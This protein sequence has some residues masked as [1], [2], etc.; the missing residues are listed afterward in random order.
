MCKLAQKVATVFLALL[1]LCCYITPAFAQDSKESTCPAF[2]ISAQK[3]LGDRILE[4]SRNELVAVDRL[5]I[6]D[7]EFYMLV[8]L[9]D[10]EDIYFLPASSYGAEKTPCL[11]G[12]PGYPLCHYYKPAPQ[13]PH[14]PAIKDWG[15]FAVCMIKEVFD[16]DITADLA[17]NIRVQLIGFVKD[18]AINSILKVLGKSNIW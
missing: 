17:S 11:P 2:N 5:V 7:E 3:F 14:E 8:N 16:I 18:R 12:D 9:E 13:P 6:F 4:S 10:S 1:C 15:K